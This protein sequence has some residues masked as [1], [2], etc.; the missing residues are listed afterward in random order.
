MSKSTK[1][2]T[3]YDQRHRNPA[4]K[5]RYE[6]DK[7]KPYMKSSSHAPYCPLSLAPRGGVFHEGEEAYIDDIVDNTEKLALLKVIHKVY[8]LFGLES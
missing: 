4:N 8:P 3:K 6:K 2:F 7:E 1:K 5:K